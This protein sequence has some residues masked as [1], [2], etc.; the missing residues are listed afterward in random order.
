[1]KHIIYIAL[2]VVLASCNQKPEWRYRITGFINTKSG[3]H[4]AI[5]YTDTIHGAN[6]DSI[7]YYNTDGTK[8]TIVEPYEIEK[9]K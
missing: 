6:R 7:W 8:L 4:E 9:L 2:L 3:K 1:M 5:A